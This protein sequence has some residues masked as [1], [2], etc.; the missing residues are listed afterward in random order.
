[1]AIVANETR[2]Y[3]AMVGEDGNAFAILGRAQ[4]ALRKAGLGELVEQFMA[5]ATADDYD[6]LLQTVMR[7]FDVDGSDDE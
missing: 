1:M 4:R 7:Y 2:P 3:L 6:H 5:D